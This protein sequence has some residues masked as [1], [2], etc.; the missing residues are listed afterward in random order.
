[1]QE[2]VARHIRGCILCCTRKPNNMNQGLYHPLCVPTRPWEHISMDFVGG[3][4]TTR[5]EHDY[6]FVVVDML[7]KMCILVPCKNK[8][9]GQEATK[10]FF[11]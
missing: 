1:M 7:N 2:Y 4:P 11:E 8:I 3:L 5:K 9:K 10:L 6:L